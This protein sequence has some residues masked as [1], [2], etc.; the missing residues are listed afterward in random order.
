MKQTIEILEFNKII[1]EL[2][3]LAISDKAKQKLL[4]LEMFLDEK[5]CEMKMNET[6]EARRILDSLGT[7]PISSM[8]FMESM[9]ERVSIGTVLMP[10]ELMLVASFIKGCKNMKR[11]LGRAEFLDC[12]LATYG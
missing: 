10:E 5:I 8:L 3:E 4:K 6:T 2:G 12:H 11:Y 9:L 7:P 1:K